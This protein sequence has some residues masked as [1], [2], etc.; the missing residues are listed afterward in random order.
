MDD[1]RNPTEGAELP[2]KLAVVLR[3]VLNRDY[4]ERFDT[5][6]DLRDALEQAFGALPSDEE[7]EVDIAP[8]AE[9]RVEWVGGSNLPTS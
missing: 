7:A 1:T 4:H 2:E 6:L 9:E 3:R 5:A 8:C